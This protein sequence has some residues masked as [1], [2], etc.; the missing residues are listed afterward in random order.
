MGLGLGSPER[1]AVAGPM[2]TVMTSGVWDLLHCGHLNVLAAAADLG[3]VLIVGVV[4]DAG[5][6]RYKHRM[7]VE[8][9][10]QRI[11]RIERLP[12][13]HV[14]LY[15]PTSDPTV[16]LERFRPEIFAHADGADDWG[17]LREQVEATG[18]RYVNLPYTDGISTSRLIERLKEGRA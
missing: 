9:V 1:D 5:V 10:Q 18:T 4:S 16:L 7:P 13:A 3:D 15:Q 17:T 8:N 14:V 6:Q 2:I 11:R 12:F